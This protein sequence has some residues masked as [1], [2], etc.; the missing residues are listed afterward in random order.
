MVW[1]RPGKHRKP[2]MTGMTIGGLPGVGGRSGKGHSHLVWGWQRAVGEEVFWKYPGLQGT[3]V[4]SVSIA[5][6]GK[7]K[8][9][10]SG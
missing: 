6:S 3:Q 9:G 2:R 5:S 7:R 4:M 1:E 10:Q 8:A